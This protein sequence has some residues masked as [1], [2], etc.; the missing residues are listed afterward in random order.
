MDSGGM[1]DDW[2][3]SPPP[4]RGTP[5]WKDDMAFR[6]VVEMMRG[7]P[8]RSVVFK[9]MRCGG[10]DLGYMCIRYSPGWGHD[11]FRVDKIEDLY[12]TANASSSDIG[13]RP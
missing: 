9:L 13:E 5:A 6:Q 4:E 1:P 10:Y 2:R 12:E 3:P 7:L 8:K 11:Y